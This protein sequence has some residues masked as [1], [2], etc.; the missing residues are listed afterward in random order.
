MTQLIQTNHTAAIQIIID[1]IITHYESVY[2][3]I[4]TEMQAI[5]SECIKFQ[6]TLD[7][8][9]TMLMELIAKSD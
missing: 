5:I 4:H 9:K 6:R 1:T 7:Q 3:Y 8:G 2:P